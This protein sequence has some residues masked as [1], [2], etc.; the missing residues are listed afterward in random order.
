MTLTPI[1]T[2]ALHGSG[3]TASS[4][5]STLGYWQ[6]TAAE[7]GLN[8]Q[9][10]AINAP[11]PKESGFAWWS[12]PDGVRSFTADEYPGFAMSKARVERAMASDMFDVVM[13]HSQ[14]AILIT[15]L[16]A[17]QQV[18][19]HPRLGYIL[20]GVAWPNPYTKELENLEFRKPAPRFL[21]IVG[22]QD[23]INP[24]EQAKRVAAALSKAGAKVSLLEHPGGHAVPVKADETLETILHWI[25]AGMRV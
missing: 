21:L 9:I 16:L 1:Q 14:G 6:I 22:Q 3:G 10:T 23:D 7:K 13:G 19:V 18:K 20:N 11:V 12:M 24:P 15:A 25:Q 4:F 8:L 2:L 17:L 5:T